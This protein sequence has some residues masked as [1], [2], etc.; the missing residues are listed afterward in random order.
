[1]RKREI[2]ELFMKMLGIYLL[3]QA[4]GYFFSL[5]SLAFF[6]ISMQNYNM[7]SSIIPLLGYA[8]VGFA[9]I[10]YSKYFATKIERVGDT[11]EEKDELT[12]NNDRLSIKEIQYIAFSVLGVYF[13]GTSLS[14]FI[15]S[16]VTVGLNGA[17]RQ[18]Y[19]VLNTVISNI[20]QFGFGFY[21][22]FGMKKRTTHGE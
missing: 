18:S 20:A 19:V 6:D 14:D 1:M 4:V 21:L 3:V 2:L 12:E 8:F 9:L 7:A 13:I 15:G 10:K 17:Y 16:I 5:I 22:L 11:A